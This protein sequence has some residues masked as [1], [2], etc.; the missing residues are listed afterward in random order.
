MINYYDALVE[1]LYFKKAI[2][3]IILHTY[4]TYIY[5]SPVCLIEKVLRPMTNSYQ[6]SYIN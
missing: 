2:V 4:N 3:H 1:E 5:S 6:R